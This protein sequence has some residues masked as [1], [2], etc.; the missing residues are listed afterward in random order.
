M[1]QLIG[2]HI[3]FRFG[4][5]RGAALLILLAVTVSGCTP[6][7]APFQSGE[8]V[9]LSHAFDEQ[10]IY[11]PTNVPFTHTTVFEGMTE[12]GYWYTSYKFCAEEHGGTHFDAPK[13]FAQ[14]GDS[15]DEIPLSR[16]IGEGIVVDV[17]A[18]AAANRDYQ[19]GVGDFLS[20]EK[21]HGRIPENAMVL[22]Y[23]G[24]DR[25]WPDAARYVGT[26][27]RGP[28][29]VAELHFPG[30]DPAA[31]VWLTAE[32][33]VSAVGLDTASI[34]HGPSTHFGSHRNLFKSGVVVFENVANLGQL[35]PKGSL[36]VAL[37]MKIAKG[38]GA[39]L[40]IVA[41]VP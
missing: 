18:E 20:W 3:S 21:R 32:R 40:R 4:I 15:V 7:R 37:P 16:L 39:P 26:A 25:F 30:L 9:D 6:S 17:T 29:A 12:K 22:L 35:P 5:A 36:I 31:A 24:F 11:W 1:K 27:A 33:K 14:G 8:W 2:R 28:Q 10:S 23:T 38:S 41:W 13:H 34:D 19:V